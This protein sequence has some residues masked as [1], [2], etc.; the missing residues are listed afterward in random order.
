MFASL[1][2]TNH[3]VPLHLQG[4]SRPICSMT[5]TNLMCFYAFECCTWFFQYCLHLNLG[6]HWK[7]SHAA[8]MYSLLLYS[9]NVCDVPLAAAK[10]VNVNVTNLQ[11]H[12]IR[13]LP[14]MFRLIVKKKRFN[15]YIIYIQ[16]LSLFNVLSFLFAIINIKKIDN[17]V[18]VSVTAKLTN[19]SNF[20]ILIPWT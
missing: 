15:F 16:I 19:A 20:G 18:I 4:T 2:V 10:Y 5:S 17:I 7:P 13:I 8:S 14:P 3:R 9:M 1:T 6:F 12:S 11:W